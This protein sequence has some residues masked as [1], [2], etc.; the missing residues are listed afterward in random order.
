MIA[1]RG[2]KGS[3]LIACNLLLKNI[4]IRAENT[5]PR[6]I[7]IKKKNQQPF[8][9][10]KPLSFVVA[11]YSV[12]ALHPQLNGQTIDLSV[13][14]AILDRFCLVAALIKVKVTK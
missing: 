10:L 11:I 8:F 2:H 4:L 14:E 1:F 3:L 5:R 7:N 12:T 13:L 9:Y 6:K